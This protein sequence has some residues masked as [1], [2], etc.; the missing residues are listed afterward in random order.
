V[1]SLLS[2][3]RKAHTSDAAD[4][5]ARAGII[6]RGLLWLTIGLLAA[7]VALGDG[8]RADKGG[9]LE[10]LKQ[11]PFGKVLL[12]ALAAA[13]AAH[14]VFRVLEGTVGRRDEDDDRKRLL[15]R[16]WSLCRAA[17]YLFLAGSTVKLLVS[18][19]S[20]ESASKPTAE[21]MA[22]PAGRW[23]VGAVALGIVVAGIAMAVRGVRQDFTDKL[24]LPGGR[25]RKV[26]ERTG[27]AG[28]V[29]R[30]LVYALVGGF[31]VQAAAEF[32]PHKAK[33][34]DASLRALSQ[35][36]YGAV[37]LWVAVAAL[38]AFALWSFL[39]ARYRDL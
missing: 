36:S 18:G 3:A 25:M 16:A 24:D 34:L 32:D 22:W 19:P 12:V 11:Q 35:E 17:A 13:F 7:R 14:A 4:W 37:L 27:T 33:G 31:L 30:G 29:G 26:V 6:A 23:L 1:A 10:A 39:E 21:V 20:S 15:K 9:A 8:G 5:G 2:T 28:L 38:I